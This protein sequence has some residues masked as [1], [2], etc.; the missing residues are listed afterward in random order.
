MSSVVSLMFCEGYYRP[1][2]PSNKFPFDI[3]S[4]LQVVDI[5]YFAV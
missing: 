1:L 5:G 3:Y 2:F 4:D